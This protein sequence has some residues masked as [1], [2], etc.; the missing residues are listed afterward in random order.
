MV[1]LQRETP[2]PGTV[3]SEK[4]CPRPAATGFTTVYGEDRYTCQAHDELYQEYGKLDWLS[5]ELYMVQGWLKQVQRLPESVWDCPGTKNLLI[6]QNPVS[7]D[8]A[9]KESYKWQHEVTLESLEA[10]LGCAVQ[11]L[12]E[13][14][15]RMEKDKAIEDA[16]EDDECLE[17]D[18]FGDD[19]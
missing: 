14:I 18:P 7:D 11:L 19:R 10:A 3:C 16:L 13:D 6:L 17:L 5:G 8:M 1:G 2:E 4:D 15:E 12:K 9:H